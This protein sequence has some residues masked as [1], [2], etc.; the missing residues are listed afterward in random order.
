MLE[1]RGAGYEE[2]HEDLAVANNSAWQQ[3]ALAGCSPEEPVGRL[4]SIDASDPARP[5][6]TT[7]SRALYF[8][9]YFRWIRRGAVRVAANTIDPYLD[10][11]AFVN[12]DG[13]AVIV[14]KADRARNFSVDGLPA[15]RYGIVHTTGPD[16]HTVDAAAVESGDVTLRAG[17]RLE[18]AIPARGVITIYAKDAPDDPDPGAHSP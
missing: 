6:V 14:V 4:F 10:P 12:T 17:Q 16:N 7:S 2:L 11:I 1:R 5:R 8:A 15:G 18:T 13:R 3:Y 9:Q